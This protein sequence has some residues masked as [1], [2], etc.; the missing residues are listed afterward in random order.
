MIVVL[1]ITLVGFLGPAAVSH[2]KYYDKVDSFC[3]LPDTLI[4]LQMVCPA[5][6][7]V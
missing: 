6:L 5:K 2:T 4:F 3:I 7:M 1:L